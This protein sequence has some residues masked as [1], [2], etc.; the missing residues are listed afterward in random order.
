M[1]S[2]TL[3]ASSS[4]LND[5]P[6]FVIHHFLNSCRVRKNLVYQED[7]DDTYVTPRQSEDFFKVRITPWIIE[8]N[9]LSDLSTYVRH[10][11][12]QDSMCCLGTEFPE[13][14][15]TFQHASS[16]LLVHQSDL[17]VTLENRLHENV[18]N[19]FYS[20]LPESI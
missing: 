7:L 3:R 2:K 17:D 10:M 12:Y 16:V 14:S 9:T 19:T 20:L 13:M 15:K 6:P 11:E 4:Y 5:S 1:S 8:V 18:T